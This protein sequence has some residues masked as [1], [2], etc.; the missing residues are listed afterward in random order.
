MPIPVQ[1]LIVIEQDGDLN[2][3]RTLLDTQA[4]GTFADSRQRL[5]GIEHCEPLALHRVYNIRHASTP[6]G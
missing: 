4:N 1:G 3:Y 2:Y 6:I 5:R